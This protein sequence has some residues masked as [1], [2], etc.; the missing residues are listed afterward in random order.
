LQR[1]PFKVPVL[2]EGKDSE[3]FA[4]KGSLNSPRRKNAAGPAVEGVGEKDER[5]VVI[6][7]DLLHTDRTCFFY[8]KITK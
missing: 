7:D 2:T 6:K 8:G 5:Q 4:R 1:G 3:L